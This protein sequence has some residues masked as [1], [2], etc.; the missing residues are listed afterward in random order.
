MVV[1]TADST[2]NYPGTSGEIV[3]THFV[4][5]YVVVE[6]QLH[7]FLTLTLNSAECSTSRPAHFTETY[8]WYPLNRRLGGP[9][10]RYGRFEV[11]NLLPLP[12]FDIRT[13]QPLV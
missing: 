9:H 11:E 6:V 8:S 1:M 3:P 2:P 13:V 12:G 4:R 5:V 7:S 10:S